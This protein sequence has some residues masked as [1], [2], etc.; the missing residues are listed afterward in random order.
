MKQS[1]S[2]WFC[3]AVIIPII[4][5]YFNFTCQKW[6][7]IKLHPRF[8]SQILCF[9]SQLRSTFQLHQYIETHLNN[10]KIVIS[11]KEV[12]NLSSQT[13]YY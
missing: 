10:F 3:V 4:Y 6:V 5:K 9:Y 1:S 2:K 11:Y 13:Q 8:C 12:Q 7:L